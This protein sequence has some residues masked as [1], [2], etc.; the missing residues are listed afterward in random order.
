MV[1]ETRNERRHDSHPRSAEARGA[2]WSLPEGQRLPNRLEAAPL[3]VG[4][5]VHPARL[6]PS[7]LENPDGFHSRL[8]DWILRQG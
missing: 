5:P 3:L 7:D 6:L 1:C 4:D 8:K 2:L